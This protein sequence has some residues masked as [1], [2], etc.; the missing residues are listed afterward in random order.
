MCP[1][2]L[3]RLL[4]TC[5][6]PFLTSSH[7]GAAYCV[8][9]SDLRAGRVFIQDAILSYKKGA[10]LFYRPLARVE[11]PLARRARP[12]QLPTASTLRP[13][14]FALAFGRMTSWKQCV[15]WLQ[16]VD[17]NDRKEM[18]IVPNVA[19]SPP[20]SLMWTE[21][22]RGKTKSCRKKLA[23]VGLIASNWSQCMWKRPW[24]PRR[25]LCWADRTEY[26]SI[27]AWLVVGC[28][29]TR[30]VTSESRHNRNVTSIPSFFCLGRKVNLKQTSSDTIKK[31]CN[32]ATTTTTIC[33]PV[34]RLF[35]II[36]LHRL[37]EFQHYFR[38]SYSIKRWTQLVRL[39]RTRNS[40][41]CSLPHISRS[42][43]KQISVK[44]R[45]LS[46][47][48]QDYIMGKVMVYVLQH[49]FVGG[50]TR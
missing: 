35:R 28:K 46:G 30:S 9:S 24:K 1:N 11:R 17:N 34:W 22:N 23:K 18:F 32:V 20:C 37:H 50:D 16:H 40:P 42:G 31:N 3:L 43:G 7:D 21:A 5:E 15:Q 29:K 33:N 49:S 12:L 38:K 6:H 4:Q 41:S 26:A 47:N 36:Y 44:G 25:F 14:R 13:W 27:T 8:G 39:S 19:I 48:Y 2:S 45:V 10:T